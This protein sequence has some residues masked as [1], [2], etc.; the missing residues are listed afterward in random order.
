MFCS[1][2]HLIL[3]AN[4]PGRP[5]FI[6]VCLMDVNR[7]YYETALDSPAWQRAVPLERRVAAYDSALT[8]VDRAFALFIGRLR[9]SGLLDRTVLVVTSDHGESLVRGMLR[10]MT[11]LGMA[12]AFTL[13][14]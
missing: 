4:K 13:S 9:T 1:T 8:E 3:P 14:S 11:R 6:Y 7:D 2:T 12:L 10:I 5:F